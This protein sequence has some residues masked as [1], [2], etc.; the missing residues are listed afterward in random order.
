[1]TIYKLAIAD[2]YN[3]GPTLIVKTVTL[4]LCYSYS[5]S[6]FRTNVCFFH[7]FHLVL[8]KIDIL[9]QSGTNIICSSKQKFYVFQN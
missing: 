2:N 8:L 7:D 3:S 1:M 9:F 5:R 4:L 6:M